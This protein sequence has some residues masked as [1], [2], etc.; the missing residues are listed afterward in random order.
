MNQEVIAKL[1]FVR[2]SPRRF[3]LVADLI[4]GKKVSHAVELL[5]LLNQKAAKAMLKLLNSAIANA[6]HNFSFPVETLRIKTAMVDGGPMI[7][8]STPKAHGRATPIRSR[9]AHVTLALETFEPKVKSAK[10]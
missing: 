9:T 1:R 10:K 7:K 2:T 4:R 6:R 8:R 5:S 3:R